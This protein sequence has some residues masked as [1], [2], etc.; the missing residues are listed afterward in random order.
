MCQLYFIERTVLNISKSN[1]YQIIFDDEPSIGMPPAAGK[2]RLADV[3]L[4]FDLR[5]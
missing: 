5:I 1:K 4:T 2:L 3:T